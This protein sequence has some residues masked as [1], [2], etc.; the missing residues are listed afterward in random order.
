MRGVQDKPSFRPSIVC[1]ATLAGGS[2]DGSPHRPQHPQYATTG[3]VNC[4]RSLAAQCDRVI[5]T[6][7]EIRT[8]CRDLVDGSEHEICNSVP[9]IPLHTPD[10]FAKIHHV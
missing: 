7:G 1:Q 2:L 9:V 6:D 8:R 3:S 5:G 10:M 4:V